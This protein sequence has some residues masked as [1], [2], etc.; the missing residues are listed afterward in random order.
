LTCRV[1]PAIFRVAAAAE[2]RSFSILDRS[3]AVLAVALDPAAVDFLTPARALAAVF[4]DARIF[5]AK[6]FRVEVFPAKVFRAEVFLA[7]VFLAK[8]LAVEDLAAEDLAADVL[9]VRAPA[10]AALVLVAPPARAFLATLRLLSAA[11]AAATL[12]ALVLLDAALVARARAVAVSVLVRPANREEEA[13]FAAILLVLPRV[14]AEAGAF[15]LFAAFLF[16]GIL[17]TLL[18]LPRFGDGTRLAAPGRVALLG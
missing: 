18:H 9:A 6:A 2:A 11:L 4:V 10:F 16:D 12:A 5:S 7:K 15:R 8:V 17:G 13:D 1:L 14:P 3:D